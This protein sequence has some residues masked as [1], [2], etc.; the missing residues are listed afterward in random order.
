MDWTTPLKAQ[1]QDFCSRLNL[2]QLLVCQEKYLHSEVVFI[3][4]ETIE[5]IKVESIL[6]SEEIANKYNL[7][8]PL[9]EILEIVFYRKLGIE[10]FLSKFGH[11]TWLDNHK[12][13]EDCEASLVNS[14]F[15]LK[16][17]T[18]IKILVKTNQGDINNIQWSISQEEISNNRIIIFVICPKK[19]KVSLKEYSVV[20]L[21]FIPVELLS[22]KK[23]KTNI[24]L[25]HLLYISGLN[26]YIN[27]VLP[28]NYFLQKSAKFYI[29]K[30][31]YKESI[32]LY[33]KSISHNP[34]NS[35]NYFLRGICKYK[36]RDIQGALIDFSQA[37]TLNDRDDLAYHWRGYLHQQLHNYSE[38]LTNYN[39]EIL[40]NPLNYFAYFNRAITYTKLK[41]LIKAIEDYTMAIQINNSIFQGFFNRANI[42]YLLGDKESSIDDYIHVIKLQPNLVEAYYNLGIIYQEIG[43]F[44]QS[45]KSYR[46]AIKAD[47]MYLKS[48]YNLAILQANL[49]LYQQSINTYQ[50]ILKINPNFTQA[51]HNQN[52]LSLLL[53]KEGNI[54]LN[55]NVL[56]NARKNPEI[57]DVEK[58]SHQKNNSDRYSFDLSDSKQTNPY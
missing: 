9:K 33:N 17:A 41:Q 58:Q 19:F 12:Y 20:F 38:A 34:N 31:N 53:Q 47:S 51:I 23:E 52:S 50:I 21:G 43:E 49:G 22:T 36:L 16:Q 10:A 27:D 46:L 3:N 6:E 4:E 39:Q 32:S 37:I 45:L 40:I 35:K 11:L 57:I 25:S 56:Y 28:L 42:Y 15:I 2:G 14:Y 13:Y 30:G 44:Q 54:L 8:Y 29:K 18:N 26:F 7:T 24:N 55:K 48:Y 5:K 1:Q